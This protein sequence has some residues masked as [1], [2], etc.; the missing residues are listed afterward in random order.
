MLDVFAVKNYPYPVDRTCMHAQSS[1]MFTT[2]IGFN[3]VDIGFKNTGNAES[4][5]LDWTIDA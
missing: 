2:G 5:P 4:C 1:C 3:S